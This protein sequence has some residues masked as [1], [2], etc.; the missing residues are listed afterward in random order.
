MVNEFRTVN[1]QTESL[2][3]LFIYLFFTATEFDFEHL[4]SCF[5]GI[6][7]P[8]YICSNVGDDTRGYE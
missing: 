6:E 8:T 3:T 5:G 1:H 7:C 2:F 4:V